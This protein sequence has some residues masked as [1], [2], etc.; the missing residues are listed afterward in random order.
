MMQYRDNGDR[1]ERYEVDNISLCLVAR[2]N[3]KAFGYVPPCL[4]STSNATLIMMTTMRNILLVIINLVEEWIFPF[5]ILPGGS[6]SN[7]VGGEETPGRLHLFDFPSG[8]RKEEVK[9]NNKKE[10]T[11]LIPLTMAMMNASPEGQWLAKR[12][13]AVGYIIVII[14]AS[15]GGRGQTC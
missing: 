13:S 12:S 6:V 2:V 1:V 3:H 7:N 14:L 5:K 11:L 9:E 4:S 15:F 10:N 8:T